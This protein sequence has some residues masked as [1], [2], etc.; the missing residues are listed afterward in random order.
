MQIYI[1]NPNFAMD[2]GS[3]GNTSDVCNQQLMS[4]NVLVVMIEV[5]RTEDG[6]KIACDNE[7]SYKQEWF[8]FMTITHAYVALYAPCVFA[9]F[10]GC[11]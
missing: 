6:R 9:N 11:C 3:T 5:F 4:T 1:N 10:M 8:F 7:P 2:L